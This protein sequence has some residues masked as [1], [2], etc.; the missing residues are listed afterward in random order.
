MKTLG[1]FQL[2]GQRRIYNSKFSKVINSLHEGKSEVYG[3]KEACLK[4]SPTEGEGKGFL[5]QF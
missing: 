4:F 5:G 2:T 1:D 3:H